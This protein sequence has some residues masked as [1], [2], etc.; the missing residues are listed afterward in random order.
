MEADKIPYARE[1]GLGYFAVGGTAGAR[2]YLDEVLKDLGTGQIQGKLN[3]IFDLLAIEVAEPEGG[4]LFER[5]WSN[6]VRGLLEQVRSIHPHPAKPGP[7]AAAISLV[8]GFLALRS[9]RLDLLEVA[10]R[11]AVQSAVEGSFEQALGYWLLAK[12][13]KIESQEARGALEDAWKTDWFEQSWVAIPK[14]LSLYWVVTIA[15]DQATAQLHCGNPTKAKE[16]LDHL[17]QNLT[18]VEGDTFKKPLDKLYFALLHA[19]EKQQR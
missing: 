7:V 6:G 2:M 14:N 19:N 18:G 3:I 15:L 17:T 1:Q 5:R 13:Y 4:E 11:A 12:R 10:A 9:K 16:V 8:E